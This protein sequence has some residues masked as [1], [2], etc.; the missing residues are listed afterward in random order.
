[1]LVP[2][3]DLSSAK[4]YQK[5][6]SYLPFALHLFTIY[7]SQSSTYEKKI[8]NVLP[9]FMSRIIGPAFI[10]IIHFTFDR[11]EIG[12]LFFREGM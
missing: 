9:Y 8:K 1:M 2:S 5:E 7:G 3:T 12:D 11:N 6:T 4:C 10:I